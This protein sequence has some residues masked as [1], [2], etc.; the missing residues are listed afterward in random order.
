MRKKGMTIDTFTKT[1]H[2]IVEYAE[3]EVPKKNRDEN[4]PWWNKECSKALA[5]LFHQTKK[6]R[7]IGDKN[8]F[9]VMTNQQKT[10]KKITKQAKKDGWLN[11]CSS[12]TRESSISEIW[13][14]AKIFKGNSRTFSSNESCDEW[15]EEF[16]NKHSVPTPCNQIDFE[17]LIENR[18]EYFDN[19]ISM[20]T[21]QS[22][23][24]NL[25]KSASGIDKISNNILKSLP[26]TAIEILTD[27]FNNIIDSGKIPEEWKITKVIPL[28]KPGKPTNEASSKRPI[29]IFGKVR[30]LFES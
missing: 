5:L 21:V 8:S 16:M 23:I 29:S 7:Q 20:K 6:F 17:K 13:K 10:F 1:L 18:C 15:I 4:K 26:S 24:N 19:P 12:I 25:K 2:D 9:D 14:M 30:R 28:Q 27:I 22:K 3:I 11:Y